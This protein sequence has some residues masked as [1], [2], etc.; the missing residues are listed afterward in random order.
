MCMDI[1]LISELN[2]LTFL[3]KCMTMSLRSSMAAKITA[4]NCTPK[5]SANHCWVLTRL[6][7]KEV[8]LNLKNAN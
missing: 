2:Q 7:K 5:I 8:L 4:P 6:D 3:T 1:E